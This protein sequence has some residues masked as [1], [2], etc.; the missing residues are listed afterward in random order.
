VVV[1]AEVADEAHLDGED[2]GVVVPCFAEFC[3]EGLEAGLEGRAVVVESVEV[4]GPVLVRFSG[5]ARGAVPVEEDAGDEF[6]V[7]VFEGDAGACGGDGVGVGDDA[8]DGVAGGELDGIPW[9]VL[10]DEE[11]EAAGFVIAEA[12]EGIVDGSGEFCEG[13]GDGAVG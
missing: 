2:A 6:D 12:F 9:D 4:C 13:D 8:V 11:S 3:D 7:K 5:G 1:F 10:S